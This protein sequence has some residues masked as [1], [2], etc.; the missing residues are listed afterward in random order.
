MK[1]R[2]SVSI[3]TIGEVSKLIE[4]PVKTIRY[5]ESIGLIEPYKIDSNTNYRYYTMNEIFK[6]D[7]VRFLGKTLGIPLKKV[8]EY[9]DIKDDPELLKIYLEQQKSSL[10]NQIKNLEDSTNFTKLKYDAVVEKEKRKL[11]VV[12]VV[13][14][15]ERMVYAQ[16]YEMKRYD[17][18][19]IYIRSLAM[20]LDNSYNHELYLI[21]SR[22]EDEF[23]VD[24]N[25]GGFIGL[26]DDFGEG[27]E[28]ILP[29]GRYAQIYYNSQE[30]G[31]FR[32]IELIREYFNSSQAKAGS[33]FIISK[34]L[35][36]ITSMDTND[37]C[38]KLEVGIE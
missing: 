32:A 11:F 26:D 4:I 13:D 29:K 14:Q 2:D 31:R 28:Y 16:Y 18:A 22:V 15:P 27:H 17:D 37:Y 8:K 10:Q 19:F 7:F 25:A 36:D 6:L 21:Q 3:Y 30:E 9:V 35:I 23:K 33:D 34:K 38:F 20:K 5:Y 1:I 24:D 12:E